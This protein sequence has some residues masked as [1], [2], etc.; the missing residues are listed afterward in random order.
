M[1]NKHKQY[2]KACAVLLAACM[3]AGTGS[4]AYAA[5]QATVSDAEALACKIDT[6]GVSE[7]DRKFKTTIRFESYN[8]ADDGFNKETK[9]VT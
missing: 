4:Y 9:Q 3:V 7:K 8:N 2:R 6:D 1:L 5:P